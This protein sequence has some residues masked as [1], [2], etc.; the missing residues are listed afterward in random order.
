MSYKIE[1]DFMHNGYR[2]VVIMTDMGHRCGYVGVDNTHQF[3]G[4]DYSDTTTK[5]MIDKIKDLFDVHGGITYSG[6]EKDYP[7]E[8]NGI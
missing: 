2:C 8:S 6:G 5:E 4:K 7:V 1:K 3:F